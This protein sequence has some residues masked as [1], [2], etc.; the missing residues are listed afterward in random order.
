MTSHA[1]LRLILAAVLAIIPAGIWGYIFYKKQVGR[2][3]MML[4]T[5]ATASLFVTPLLFYKFL[6]QYFPWLDAFQY[7]ENFKN[8]LIGFST[9]GMIPLNI[10]LTFMIVGIIE[11][12]AKLFAVKM[13]DKKR[14]CSI[15]DAIEM[16]IMAALGFSFAENVLYFY[17]I[18]ATRGMEDILYP[19]IFRSLFSTFAHIMFS[20]IMGYYYGMALFSKNLLEEP[21]NRGK[22]HIT[23][24]FAKALHF[25]KEVLLHEEKIAE[26]LLI[27]I[28]LHAVFNIFLEMNWV[29]LLVPFLTGG[30]I[31]LSHLF[32]KKKDQ[33]EYCTVGNT[34]NY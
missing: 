8:D 20:G 11:E 4:V 32:T 28:T 29:F 17:N 6:W 31:Y 22:W 7:T 16:N 10:I 34:R 12:I 24:M 13:T 1:I 5:F 15:D 14:I 27:A 19:F 26:G 18:I 21:K 9:F 23:K 30:Y 2:K 3:R 25:K 33:K